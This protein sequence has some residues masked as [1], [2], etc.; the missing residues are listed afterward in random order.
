MTQR[1]F[2]VLTQQGAAADAN[3]KALG[4]NL[5][6]SHYA[7]GDGGGINY[8]P[9]A[10]TLINATSLVNEVYRGA[11]NEL[12]V[13]PNNPAR[14]Y[15]EGI[16][17]VAVGGWTV[18]EA[19]WFLSDGTLYAVTKFPPSYKSIPSDGAATELP[20]RTYIATGSTDTVELKIDPTVVLAT[21]SYVENVYQS[22]DKR[23]L[24]QPLSQNTQTK[25]SYSYLFDAPDLTAVLPNTEGL[26]PFSTVKFRRSPGVKSGTLVPFDFNADSES[27]IEG[28][29][30]AT[31]LLIEDIEGV[32]HTDTQIIYSTPEAI[33]ATLNK[34]LDW[35]ITRGS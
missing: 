19:G 20:I 23:D 5:Q 9:D 34:N 10:E 33:T 7:V 18:R 25:A 8:A 13:D 17:P 32:L 16:V 3:A 30:P 12:R 1:F 28:D 22:L 11:I 27:R 29:S 2:T 6:L 31:N 15:V 26:A 4:Q 21:R 35:E 24:L 14:Y